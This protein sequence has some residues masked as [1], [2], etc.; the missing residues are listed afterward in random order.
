MGMIAANT[1]HVFAYYDVWLF[2]FR[3]KFRKCDSFR[4][5]VGFL[6]RRLA[7]YKVTPRHGN[8]DIRK[9]L[10]Y[11]NT[12]SGIRTHSSTCLAPSIAPSPLSIGN[13]L[14]SNTVRRLKVAR[15]GLYSTAALCIADC[16][17]ALNDVVPSFISRG[18][19]TPSGA[20]ALY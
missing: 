14:S 20:G 7:R 13:R 8:T 17:L 9:T 3:I 15:R 12:Q 10:T 11:V 6:D 1:A 16:A 2:Q 5:F 19:T 4:H 18:A